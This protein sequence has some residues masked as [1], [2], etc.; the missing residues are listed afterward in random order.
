MTRTDWI[1]SFIAVM[2]V[3]CVWL[4]LIIMAIRSGSG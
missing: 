1:V 4:A 2:T 3:W